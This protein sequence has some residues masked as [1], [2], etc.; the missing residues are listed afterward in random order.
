MTRQQDVAK[1]RASLSELEAAQTPA[2]KNAAKSR[3]NTL[4][5]QVALTIQDKQQRQQFA[6]GLEADIDSAYG[7]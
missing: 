5:A 2:E 6:A 4:G 1:I 3:A 7:G